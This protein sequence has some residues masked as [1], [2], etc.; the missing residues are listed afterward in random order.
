MF[1]SLWERLG[2][3]AW[4]IRPNL[5]GLLFFPAAVRS[6]TFF[7]ENKR[8]VRGLRVRIPPKEWPLLNGS[9]P[10]LAIIWLQLYHAFPAIAA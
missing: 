4:R 9:A 6:A 10:L 8:P 7:A 5:R 2:E 1:L 3:G